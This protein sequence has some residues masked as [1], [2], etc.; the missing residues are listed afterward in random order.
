MFRSRISSTLFFVIAFAAI[1][2]LLY[3]PSFSVWSEHVPGQGEDGAKNFYTLLYHIEHDSSPIWFEGMNYPHGEHVLYTDNQPLVANA[4]KAL[5][6]FFPVGRMLHWLLPALIL[7]SYLLGGWCLW[8]IMLRAHAPNW[9]AAFAA[10]GIMLLSPQ[11][12]RLG[13]HY[14]LAYAAVIPVLLFLLMGALESS[15][16]K[17]WLWVVG[18]IFLSAFLHPYFLIMQSLF[19]LCLLAFKTIADGRWKAWWRPLVVGLGPILLF[20]LVM[21]LTDPVTDRPTTPYGFMHYRA[22]WA[23]VFLPLEY[24]YYKALDIGGALSSEGS[25]Y[26]GLFAILGTIFMVIKRLR[27]S[28]ENGASS[29]SQWVLLASIPVLLLSLAFPF[30]IWKLDR[31]VEYLG[32]LK[33]FR[34]IGRFSFVFFYAI[35]LFVAMHLGRWITQQKRPLSYAVGGIALAL[36]LLE[37]VGLREQVV[38][39]THSG[40]QV[41]HSAMT[42]RS[43]PLFNPNDFQAILPLPYFHIGSENLRTPD[44]G[45]FRE[46]AFALSYETGMSL[47]SVQ[48]SRTSLGQTLQSF[49]LVTEQ[50]VP[51]A[52]LAHEHVD[53]RPFLLCVADS[54]SLSGPQKKLIE[55]AELLGGYVGYSLFRLPLEAFKDIRNENRSAALDTNGFTQVSDSMFYSDSTASFAYEPF[56][57]AP[58]FGAFG[59]YGNEV[60]RQDWTDLIPNGYTFQ[61]ARSYELSFWLHAAH[62]TVNTQLWLW[63]RKGETE[64][65]FEVTELADHVAAVDG[66]WLLIAVSLSTEQQG[67]TLQ[68][69]LHRDGP[70]QNIHYDEVLLR[71]KDQHLIRQ[72]DDRLVR[73]NRFFHLTSND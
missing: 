64:V 25:Y 55:H 60:S 2:L 3:A 67:N 7:L 44:I 39:R 26:I 32:P 66:E 18:W 24:D 62:N 19:V 70:S 14:S 27:S 20:Q 71:P 37:G 36:L 13:G 33:Q 8:R 23:S 51:P 56:E 53:E 46:H 40:T 31:L 41:F 15:S 63:E 73:N 61:P 17:K 5:S 54:A 43:H 21:W 11:L 10:T 9:F 12:I 48:M 50:I 35:N 38:A 30:T 68:L 57:K 69:M 34:G 28:A 6:V 4:L 49:Q 29:F 65:R 52:L 16:L 1:T 58:S 42:P 59:T 72:A 47:L 45:S 22:T